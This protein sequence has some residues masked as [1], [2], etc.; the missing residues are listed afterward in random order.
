MQEIYTSFVTLGEDGE[1]KKSSLLL[2]ATSSHNRVAWEK[3]LTKVQSARRGDYTW[4]PST[5]L[6]PEKID[7]L[8]VQEPK[9]DGSEVRVSADKLSFSASSSAALCDNDEDIGEAI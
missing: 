7:R 3:M 9:V 6:C 4:L 2:D 1:T 8:E 5:L